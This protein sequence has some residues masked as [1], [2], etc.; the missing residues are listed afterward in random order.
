MIPNK[1]KIPGEKTTYKLTGNDHK[2]PINIRIFFDVKEATI[3]KQ[4][5]SNNMKNV[6]TTG[7]NSVGFE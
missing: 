1:A 3:A 5:G 7:A 4:A 6:F 2:N